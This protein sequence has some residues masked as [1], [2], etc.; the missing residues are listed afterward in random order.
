MSSFLTGNFLSS[1]AVSN[2]VLS[3]FKGLTTVFGWEQVDPLS[4]RHRIFE[5]RPFETL[6]TSQKR[7][8]AISL[9]LR[10]LSQ[11]LDILVPVS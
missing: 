11:A 2:Q 6:K 9:S 1:Q 10:S 5:G 8:L 4:Y 3:A 7:K